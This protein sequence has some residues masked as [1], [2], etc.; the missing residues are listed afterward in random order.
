MVLFPRQ[1]GLY[2]YVTDL[3]ESFVAMPVM[4]EYRKGLILPFQFMVKF[5]A[6]DLEEYTEHEYT[7]SR[8]YLYRT[9]KQ[10]QGMAKILNER[11]VA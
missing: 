5:A 9:Q 3:W 1:G 6:L 8:F 2:W 7:V 10:A 11:L 4:V